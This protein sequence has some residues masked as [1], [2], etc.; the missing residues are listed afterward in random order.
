[1]NEAIIS[2]LPHR[3]SHR[4]CLFSFSKISS[5]ITHHFFETNTNR[6]SSIPYFFIY[7]KKGLLYGATNEAEESTL[8][9]EKEIGLFCRR[10][11]HT[12]NF[13]TQS[14]TLIRITGAH[15]YIN[16]MDNT[17]TAT[18]TPSEALLCKM[19]CGFFV[20]LRLSMD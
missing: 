4:H 1:M 12:Q 17:P 6:S 16:T 19:G 5:Q 8:A 14:E 20:S 7:I 11:T 2:P 13:N 18:N 15:I 9:E 10:L 3:G